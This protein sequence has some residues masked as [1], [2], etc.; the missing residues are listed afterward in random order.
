[1]RK[2][3]QEEHYSIKQYSTSF[4]YADD[5]VV[6][7]HI[8]KHDAETAEEMTTAAVRIGLTINVSKTKYMFNR[9][10]RG[11]EPEETEIN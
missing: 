7:G 4:L 11:T 2:Q 8:V 1:M 3:I 6:L 9:K 10:K 5:T